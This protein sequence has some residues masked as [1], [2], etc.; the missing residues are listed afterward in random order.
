VPRIR[1]KT[2]QSALLVI[3]VQE[4]LA[5]SI[6]EIERT[7]D[8]IRFLT[9]VARLLGVPTLATEQNPAR[10]GGTV[11][12]IRQLLDEPIGK[13][14]FSACGACAEA[15]SRS[16]RNQIVLVGIETHIC[17]SQTAH[18]LMDEGH[19][20]V[21]CPDAVSARSLD[22][23]KLGMERIRD[24]GGVPAHTEAVAYEWLR[25]ADHELF[26]DALRIVKEHA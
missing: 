13:M 25:S 11:Q 15:I 26:R 12:A 19:D 23:H 10:M 9:R 16:R 5:P 14:E 3:D 21:V 20:V 22:R 2:D 7:I 24:A 8:R 17:V 6:F 4:A 1:L 18:D